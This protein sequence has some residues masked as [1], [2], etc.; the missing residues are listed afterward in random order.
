[1]RTTLVIDENLLNEA[2]TLSH[3]KTKR[4][5]IEKALR[6]YVRR[7]KAKKLLNLEGKVELSFSLDEFLEMRKSDV[8]SR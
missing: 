8:P 3:A 5:T 6:E 7:K 1:M 2:K 4:E